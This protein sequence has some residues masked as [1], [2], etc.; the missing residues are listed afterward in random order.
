MLSHGRHELNDRYGT[1]LTFELVEEGLK[2][3][4]AGEDKEWDT[5]GDL[6]VIRHYDGTLESCFSKIAVE[7]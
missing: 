7:M 2:V 4:S 1:P 3:K 5:E 6:W